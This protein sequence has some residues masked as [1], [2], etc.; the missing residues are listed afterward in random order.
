MSRVE[1]RVERSPVSRLF[2]GLLLIGFGVIGV[3]AYMH[4]L[5]GFDWV[6][7]WPGA[8]T[9]VGIAQV[10]S[11]NTARRLGGGVTTALIGVWFLATIRHWHGLD[12]GNSWPLALVAGGLGEVVHAIATP[13]YRRARKREED[14][15]VVCE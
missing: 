10:F 15:H 8:V 5:D 11:A 4:L 9:V 12:W 6:T 1:V 2:W 14:V 7:S 3:M 13:V